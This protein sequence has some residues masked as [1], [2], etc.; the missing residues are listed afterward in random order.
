MAMS[1]LLFIAL[2]QFAT[3]YI[4]K[5]AR[6]PNQLEAMG[7]LTLLSLG[8]ARL[9]VELADPL[10]SGLALGMQTSAL[11]Y[12]VP[13]AGF[14]ML[15]RILINS[16]SAIVWILGTAALLGVLMDQQVLFSV[17]FA[18]SGV[19]A[20]G[21][22]AHRRERVGVLRAGLLTGLVN[23]A[24]ALLL[25]LVQVHLGDSPVLADAATQPLWDVVFAFLGGMLSGI[26]VLGLVPVFELF[27]FVTDYRL[28]ELANLNHPLLRQLMLRAPGT[29]TTP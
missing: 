6:E 27:G 20:A 21:A 19:T 16:E 25:N 14:A 4:K 26:V 3:G 13:F 10:T 22:L 28:L 18:V 23:A 5:F 7:I 1:A 17:F 9:T 2:F 24:A 29:S 11:W 12:L 15:A 8:I